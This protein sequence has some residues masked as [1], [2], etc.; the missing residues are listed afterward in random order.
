MRFMDVIS[1]RKSL[2]IRAYII[3]AFLNLSTPL[4]NNNKLARGAIICLIVIA[5]IIPVE[6]DIAS[7]IEGNVEWLAI[8]R[9]C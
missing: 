3:Q 2:S 7:T 1:Q 5:E 6:P 9:A 4:Y 8:V